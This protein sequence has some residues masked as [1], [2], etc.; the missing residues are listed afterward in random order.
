[1]SVH[2]EWDNQDATI[3]LWSFIVRWTWGEFD[4]AV[5]TVSTMF[6]TVDHAVDFI[7]D[8]RQ[9]SI[10]PPDVVSH[11][12]QKYLGKPEKMGRFVA[13]GMD[14]NLRLFWD[15]FTDLPYAR[16][17]KAYYFETLDEARQFCHSE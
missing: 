17:L 5:K 6:E 14:A 11:I 15:T 9:M 13:V 4:D 7:I 1:M 2:V 8:V 3:I 16:H 12:K 10:L